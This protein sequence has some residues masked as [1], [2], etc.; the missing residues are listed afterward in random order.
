MTPHGGIG[1]VPLKPRVDRRRAAAGVSRRRSRR[2]LLLLLV[3]LG[4]G[5][6]RPTS[7]AHRPFHLARPLGPPATIFLADAFADAWITE[8]SGEELPERR[9]LDHARAFRIGAVARFGDGSATS[10]A[11]AVVPPDRT[12]GFTTIHFAGLPLWDDHTYR[13]RARV[14]PEGA[15]AAGARVEIVV[16][17]AARHV[18][19]ATG[20]VL[21]DRVLG[22]GEVTEIDV[23]LGLWPLRKNFQLAIRVAATDRG[24]A[25]RAVL[26]DRPRLE[27]DVDR[28]RPRLGMAQPNLAWRAD[29]VA[30]VQEMGRAGVRAL[31]TDVRGTDGAR[32]AELDRVVDVIREAKRWGMRVLVA[33]FLDDEDYPSGVGAVGGGDP[34]AFKRTCGWDGGVQKLSAVDPQRFRARLQRFVSAARAA[35]VRPDAFEVGNE[36][37]WACFNGDLELGQVPSPAV[38]AASFRGY[39]LMLRV[40]SETLRAAFPGIQIVTFGLANPGG[41]SGPGRAGTQAIVDLLRTTDGIDHLARFA[42]GIGIHLYPE[43]PGRRGAADETSTVYWTMHAMDGAL[44]GTRLPYWVTEWGFLDFVRKTGGCILGPDVDDCDDQRYR[45]MERLLTVMNDVTSTGSRIGDAFLYSW[46]DEVPAPLFYAVRD[47]PAGKIVVDYAPDRARSAPASSATKPPAPLPLA[48]SGSYAREGA[49]P[50]TSAC[51]DPDDRS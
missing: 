4:C 13:F 5:T 17:A 23:G 14:G 38:I 21:A 11:L 48:R 39:P 36:Y 8:S 31:R 32:R 49:M 26:V 2:A 16:A 41:S 18:T 37:D 7:P 33:S 43:D 12:V 25:G 50:A 6:G 3:A 44:G 15:R 10:D 19:D 1:M 34:T 28:L 42:D 35:G 24:G 47:T 22:P 29:A 51:D 27:T 45:A 20:A 46:A 40:A 9:R 30:L